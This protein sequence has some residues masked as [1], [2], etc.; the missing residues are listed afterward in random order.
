M[1]MEQLYQEYAELIYHYLLGLCHNPSLAEDLVQTTFL[2]AI[3]SSDSFR[4]QS[5]VSTWLFQIAKHEYIDVMRKKEN[6]NVSMEIFCQENS[7][8]GTNLAEESP[9]VL[10]YLIKEEQKERI[11]WHLHQLPEPYKE[12]FLLRIYGECSYREIASVFGKTEVWAR[13]SCFRAKEKLIER[14]KEEE[15]EQERKESDRDE[16]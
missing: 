3:E 7:Q 15:W 13:V 8:G 6:Q 12:V 4:H 16:M 1:D 5:K 10:E 9:S 11:L 2:K 14:I